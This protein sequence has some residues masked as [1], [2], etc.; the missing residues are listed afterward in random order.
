VAGKERLSANERDLFASLLREIT[1]EELSEEPSRVFDAV[2]QDSLKERAKTIQEGKRAL[3]DKRATLLEHH[4]LEDEAELAARS[5]EVHGEI[6]R[7]RADLDSREAEWRAAEEFSQRTQE[8]FGLP[9]RKM[10]D[11]ADRQRGLNRDVRIGGLTAGFA[12][13]RL[14][15]RGL[16]VTPKLDQEPWANASAWVPH[17]PN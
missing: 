6:E 12:A 2:V 14:R 8:A 16:P 5:A 17:L 13:G 9:K 15:G 7:L 3:D 1:G 10:E 11:H 4:A